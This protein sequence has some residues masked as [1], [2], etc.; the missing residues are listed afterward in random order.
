MWLLLNNQH[1]RFKSLYP[2]QYEY[3]LVLKEVFETK[4]TKKHALLEMP[5]GTGKTVCIF[6]LYLAMKVIN[7]SMGSNSFLLFIE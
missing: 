5:T 7:P 6:S 1:S 3:M 4:D 2:E